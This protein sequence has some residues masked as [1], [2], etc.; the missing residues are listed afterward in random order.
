MQSSLVAWYSE[1]ANFQHRKSI[2]NLLYNETDLPTCINNMIA[3][4]FP[5]PQKGLI[6][7]I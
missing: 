2:V 4:Y 3:G 6:G 5:L 7:K 1:S